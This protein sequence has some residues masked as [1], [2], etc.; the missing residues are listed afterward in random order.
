MLIHVMA[1]EALKYRRTLVPWLAAAGGIFPAFV[2]LLFLLTGNLP[3]TWEALEST[4][5]NFMNMLALLLVA[6]LAGQTFVCEYHG[7]KINGSLAYPIPR[8]LLFAGKLLILL[9]PVLGMF[10]VFLLSTVASGSLFIGGRPPAGFIRDMLGLVLLSA[11]ANFALVPLT[12]VVSMALKNAG[13][14][15]LSGVAYFIVYMSF[16]GSDYVRYVPPCVPDGLLKSYLSTGQIVS[17]DAGTMLAAC[18]AFF[19]LTLC[20]G[21]VWHARWER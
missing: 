17:K 18:A 7:G 20:I 4:G 9:L 19:V 2:A 13:A 5:L 16:A 14:Y 21:A 15:I 8:L 1:V 10:L 11:A 3:V 6:V 12:A